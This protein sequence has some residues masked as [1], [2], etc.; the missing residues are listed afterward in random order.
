MSRYRVVE[1]R[2]DDRGVASMSKVFGQRELYT[3]KA[4][5]REVSRRVSRVLDKSCVPVRA[6][7]AR[8][9]TRYTCCPTRRSGAERSKS[10]GGGE[11]DVQCCS[12]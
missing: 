10:C 1:R 2:R 9:C 12:E 6:A 11:E 5:L 4:V 8:A 3:C 7:A